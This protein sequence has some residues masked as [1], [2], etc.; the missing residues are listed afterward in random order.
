MWNADFRF[1]LFCYFSINS[2]FSHCRSSFS[3]TSHIWFEISSAPLFETHAAKWQCVT[4]RACWASSKVDL[5]KMHNITG[6]CSLKGACLF[7]ALVA[8]CNRRHHLSQL[9]TS[10]LTEWIAGRMPMC[11]SRHLKLLMVLKQTGQLHPP[12]LS[13]CEWHA[14]LLWWFFTEF[15]VHSCFYLF[16]TFV[17]SF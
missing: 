16:V 9:K 3:T 17:F 12:F 6:H 11:F 10:S 13:L 8:S 5:A 1:F 7:M 14:R 4:L 15:S 2:L